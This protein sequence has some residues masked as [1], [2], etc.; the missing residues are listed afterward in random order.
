MD[1]WMSSSFWLDQ[2]VFV[3]PSHSIS[4]YTETSVDSLPSGARDIYGFRPAK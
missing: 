2:A 4:P 3:E 1:E